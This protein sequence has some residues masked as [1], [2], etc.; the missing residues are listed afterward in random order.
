MI[1]QK[2]GITTYQLIIYVDD[3]SIYIPINVVNISEMWY[4]Y[5]ST[6]YGNIIYVDDLQTIGKWMQNVY[7]FVDL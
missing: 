1:F 2:C 7:N 6:P 3:S 4:H 5:L